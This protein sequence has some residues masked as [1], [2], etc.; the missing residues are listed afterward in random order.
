MALL[1]K[2]YLGSTPLWRQINWYEDG[3]PN[4]VNVSSA[5]TLTANTSAHTKGSWSQV[6][7]STS[8]NVSFLWV[9]VSSVNT[10]GSNT[11]TLID[12]ATGASGSETAFASNIAVGGASAVGSAG[13]QSI[14]FGIPIKI[15]SGTRL[16]ARIQSVV[17]GGKTGQ[18]QIFAMDTGDYSTSP[19]TVDVI[20]SDTA[21][22]QGTSFSGASGTWVE[23]IASTSQ[24]YRAIGVVL[25]THDASISNF[26]DAQFEIGVGASG[27][28]VSFGTLRYNF[29]ADE[30]L[31]ITAP[32]TFLFGRNIPAG[33]RLA[34]KHPFTADPSKYGF[35]L[36]GIP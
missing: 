3:S 36:I 19:T 29:N 18:V 2:A 12:L 17:T 6:I 16:A 13:L 26:T 24:A 4:V 11:A 25:S 31:G 21:T 14:I 33:S 7:A 28:E 35:C 27:S 9:R 34:V 1:Q 20:G 22:S 23:A 32:F 15:A 10:S 30:R 8:A 5:V